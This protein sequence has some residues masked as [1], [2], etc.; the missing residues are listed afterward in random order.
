MATIRKW[1]KQLD[2]LPKSRMEELLNA[3][4]RLNE[5]HFFRQEFKGTVELESIMRHHLIDRIAKEG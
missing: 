3:I 1:R 4:T 2:D 5:W